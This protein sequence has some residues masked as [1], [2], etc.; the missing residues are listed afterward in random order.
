MS[1]HQ[2]AMLWQAY[3]SLNVSIAN[4]TTEIEIYESQSI[5]EEES[6]DSSIRINWGFSST[7]TKTK[8]Q[9]WKSLLEKYQTLQQAY[10]VELNRLN[11]VNL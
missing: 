5:T 11:S 8:L 7:D 1:S 10:L 2:E 6:T 4:V 3:Y 9:Y